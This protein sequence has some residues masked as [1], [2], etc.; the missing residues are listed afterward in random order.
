[1]RSDKAQVLLLGA[2]PGKPL[3]PV[4]WTNGKNIIY[5]SLGHWEDWKIE[6]FRNMM[7]NAVEY[8]LH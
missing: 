6:S 8:L 7:F 1:L 4:L 2:N 5:T 3:E